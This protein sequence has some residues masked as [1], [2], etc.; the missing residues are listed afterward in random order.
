MSIEDAI[1]Q[2]MVGDFDPES[3]T[4]LSDQAFTVL[5]GDLPF[6][7]KLKRVG[8]LLRQAELAG[9]ED[10]QRFSNV[11]EY[12]YADASAEELAI[13]QTDDIAWQA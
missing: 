11:I 7:Q 12:I 5:R 2:A 9:G 8:E 10:L 1:K 4:P 3:A 13:L 6:R